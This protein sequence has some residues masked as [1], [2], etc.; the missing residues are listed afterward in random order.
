MRW[1]TDEAYDAE[2]D[3][4]WDRMLVDYA[5][6]LDAIRAD[7]PP[8]LL[9]LATDPEL[10]LH[11]AEFIEVAVDPPSKRLE[12][13][14]RLGNVERSWLRL[15]F[16][17]ADVVPENYQKLGFAIGATYA[18]NHWGGVITVILAQEIETLRHGRFVFRLRLWP[19]HAFSIEFGSMSLERLASSPEPRGPGRFILT[20]TESQ[21]NVPAD[22]HI[23][24]TDAD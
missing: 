8:D 17:E 14:V 9:A 18:P 19:F 12:M 3:A 10:H 24:F 13:V 11:D 21:Q 1:F 4:T 6:H 7:L 20:G 22:R 2:D 16:R 23:T 15:A 5:R